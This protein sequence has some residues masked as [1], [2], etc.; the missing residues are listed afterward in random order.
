M[1]RIYIPIFIFLMG[2]IYLSSCS[3]DF[4]DVPAQGML[5]GE[6]DSTLPVNTALAEG[7]LLSVYDPTHWLYPWG[8]SA[9]VSFNVASD[10]IISGGASQNDR[11]EYEA[12]D[13]FALDPSND[14]ALQM[15]NRFY[16]GVARSNLFISDYSNKASND[17]LARFVAEAKFLRA[18]YYF[19]L[20]RCYGNIPM[21]LLPSDGGIPASSLEEVYSQLE[22]DLSE[23]INSGK[24]PKKSQLDSE[25]LKLS[26]VTL[27]AAKTLLG[28][29]YLYHSTML[30]DS[31]MNEAYEQL[32]EVYTSGEYSLVPDFR[33]LW[34]STYEM[35]DGNP[36][37]I[38]EVY[39]TDEFG[40][41]FGATEIT[42]GNLDVH[43]MGVRNL[44]W[45]GDY[46]PLIGGWGFC[47]PTQKMVDAFNSE[48][49]TLRLNAT[50]VSGSWMTLNGGLF[51]EPYD[52]TGYWNGKYRCDENPKNAMMYAQNEIVLRFAEVILMLA[53]IEYNRG[54]QSA[55][56]GYLN[57]IRAR[58]GLPL[59]NSSGTNLFNDIVK[60]RQLELALESNRYFDLIR[61]GL[62]SEI[63]G[64]R[65]DRSGLWPIPLNALL[66][67]TQLEQNPGY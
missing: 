10:D 5:V 56:L 46:K 52:A 33:S 15:W 12:A 53:E 11:P 41:N 37:N 40:Y 45:S 18:Y 35:K 54:N 22:K 55:A 61:W 26:R 25:G 63:P 32:H 24:L 27:G 36:E 64:Y 9:Y 4:L 31:K 43:L 66:T 17:S 16:T 50:V 20:V 62:T 51:D 39:Y 7:E 30:N 67:D 21:P 59:K 14:G 2:L 8:M 29:V 49:D 65:A 1:K 34:Q 38:F 13:K 47:K 60:E 44:S 48:N 28:K 23:A 57:E 6:P 42:R 19:N 58:V 3:K